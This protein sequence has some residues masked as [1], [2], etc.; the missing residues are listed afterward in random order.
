M[1][2]YLGL[3]TPALHESKVFTA[4]EAWYWGI[5]TNRVKPKTQKSGLTQTTD[6]VAYS[7]NSSIFNPF[8]AFN[9]SIFNPQDTKNHQ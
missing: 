4:F 8:D 7:F 9:P 5:D 1:V 2:N 6:T 3:R